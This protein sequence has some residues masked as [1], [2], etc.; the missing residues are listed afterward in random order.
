VVSI[1]RPRMGVLDGTRIARE[2]GF[3]SD[4]A[5]DVK[6]WERRA[7]E[8]QKR[9]QQK[10]SEQT[11]ALRQRLADAGTDEEKAALEKEAREADLAFQRESAAL[12]EQLRTYSRKAIAS[13][14]ARLQ[15]FVEKVA[16]RKHLW[17]VVERAG[18][19]YAVQQADITEEV[20]AAA[21]GAFDQERRSPG[22]KT[23]LDPVE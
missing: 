11:A 1:G 22:T 23:P 16:R 12:R 14:R 4:F 20:T 5:A 8:D 19:V 21:R 10:L 13:F 17:V 15:P 6:N 2:L 3:E 18:V 7:A 9:A